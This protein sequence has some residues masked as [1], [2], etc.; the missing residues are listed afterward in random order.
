MSTSLLFAAVLAIQTP[1]PAPD[2]AQARPVGTRA[3][4]DQTVPVQ[5]G[6]RLDLSDC[7]GDVVV[8][9]WERSEVRV[10]AEHSA[11]TRVR[12][13]PR[14]QTIFVSTDNDRQGAADFDLTVPAWLN[15]RIVGQYCSMEIDG[16]TGSVVVESVEGDVVL[17][18]LGGSVTATSMEGKVTVDGGRGR[19]Q[20]NTSDGDIAIGKATGE[21]IAESIDGDIVLTDVQAQALEVSTVDGDISFSGTV[22][23]SGRY[24]FTTHDGDVVLVLPEN[25]SATFGVR[26][27]ESRKVDS[28]LPLKAATAGVRGRRAVYTLGGGSAQVEVESFGGSLVIRKPG[29]PVRRGRE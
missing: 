12:V 3:Q 5:R 1:A 7:T 25:T 27:Y 13:T 2:T 28:T 16:V 10:R 24:L 29:E 18:G 4:T 8:T 6:S 14:D 22:Q 15:L 17:R 20:V 9:T 23:A 11:R 26:T 21:I 19:I